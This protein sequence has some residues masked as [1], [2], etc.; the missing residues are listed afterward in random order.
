[1][2][3]MQIHGQNLMKLLMCECRL[4]FLVLA[5]WRIKAYLKEVKY[6]SKFDLISTSGSVM[7]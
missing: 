3:S 5:H 2:A 7:K 6:V 4:L 1:M